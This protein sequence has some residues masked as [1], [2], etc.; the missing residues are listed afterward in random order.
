MLAE[1][2][3]GPA[4]RVPLFQRRVMSWRGRCWRKWA[5]HR[6]RSWSRPS[7]S[8]LWGWPRRGSGRRRGTSRK[9]IAG[10]LFGGLRAVPPGP[11]ADNI[12]ALGP[13]GRVHL[14]AG[15]MLT[16]LRAHL[17][18]DPGYLSAESWARLHRAE[19]PE[20]LRDGLGRGG[21]RL[22]P[23][24]VEHAVVRADAAASGRGGR[25]FRRGQNSAVLEEVAR[26]GRG[27][28][29]GGPC[30]GLSAPAAID[31]LAPCQKARAGDDGGGAEPAEGCRQDTE[32]GR[33]VECGEDQREIGE[34]RDEAGG[35]PGPSPRRSRNCAAAMIRP[36]PAMP[37]HCAEVGGCQTQITAKAAMQRPMV[38]LTSRNLERALSVPTGV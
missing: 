23:F 38:L 18:G 8:R 4:G 32:E 37:T 36:T 10:G 7:C 15:D 29:G 6:G 22:A 3:A 34:G 19:G 16:Y 33:V 26:P 30:R 17:V 25:G 28:G 20:G 21:R 2:A 24:G 14:S 27:G 12:P 31:P 5:L 9:G 13:A 1:G 35:R 11:R